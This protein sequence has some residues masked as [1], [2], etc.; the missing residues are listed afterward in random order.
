MT[1]YDPE[2]FDQ[3]LK[4]QERKYGW[5]NLPPEYTELFVDNT[6]QLLV[7]LARYKFVV[8][9]LKKTDHVLE[10]GSGNG[11]G[12]AF[13]A[14]NASQAT[15]IEIE[16]YYYDAAV[17]INRRKNIE[18]LLQSIFDHDLSRKYDAVVS[19]D[20]IEHLKEEDGALLVERMAQHCKPNGMVVIGT[21]SIYSYP[22][23][24]AYSRASHIKCYDQQE[25]VALFDK[26]FRRTLAFSMND[27][28]VH[29]GFSK[30]AWYYFVLGFGPKAAEAKNP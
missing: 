22:Y 2:H 3:L 12:T 19:F 15:G 17:K 4:E 30:L 6:L 7:K 27:E 20:V 18:F 29:T 1:E 16:P 5:I 14:Q 21:P 11:L 9:Q 28:M 25:L 10:V 13:L 23:Q 26:Y 8:R 24:S